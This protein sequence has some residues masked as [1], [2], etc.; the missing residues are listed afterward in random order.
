MMKVEAQYEGSESEVTVSHLF[1]KLWSFSYDA[2]VFI[3]IESPSTRPPLYL[4]E[5]VYMPQ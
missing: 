2:T 1:F 5:E 3:V 4:G